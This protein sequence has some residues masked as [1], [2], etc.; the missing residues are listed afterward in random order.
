VL[1][2]R[3]GLPYFHHWDESWVTDNTR[4]MLQTRD[5]KPAT[6]QYGA[7]LSLLGAGIFRT[8][9]AILPKLVMDPNDGVLVRW[10]D[11][12]VT[13]VISASG[14]FAVY[15]A[16]RHATLGDD[17]GR[18][19]GAYAAI[20][21]ATAAELVSHGRYAVTDANLAA[22]CAWSLAFAAL[23]FQSGSLGSAIG[24]VLFAA[25][26]F[27]FKLTALTALAIPTLALALKPLRHGR[28]R[29]PALDHTVLLA[30]LPASAAVFFVLNP[31][32]LIDWKEA[33][34]DIT[35]RVTQVVTGGVGVFMIKKP[36][37]EHLSAV[38]EGIGLYGFHR[39]HAASLL[40]A[41][42]GATGLVIGVRG[43]SRLC[44]VAAIH[45]ALAILSV[46]MT[47]R[48]YLYRNYLVALPALCIGFGVAVERLG[49]RLRAWM[50]TRAW[51][52]VSLGMAG[53]FAIVYVAVP[54]AQAVE[55]QR[56]SADTRVRAVDWIARQPHDHSPVTVATNHV[57]AS[58]GSGQN[59]GA[60]A[61]LA[62]PGIT[63]LGD[64]ETSDDAAASRADYI[65][66]VSYAASTGDNGRVWRFSTVPG[67]GEVARFEANPY[68]HNF[69]ITPT[70]SGRFDA[71]VLRRGAGQTHGDARAVRAPAQPQ[72]P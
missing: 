58:D 6:Y 64:V 71:V 68:E 10:I 34:N 15:V 72:R 2:L 28:F 18:V 44:A 70:W 65:L 43:R 45:A 22:L 36:G 61:T 56:L 53:A 27:S 8:I 35:V 17:R 63:F 25:L 26:A 13:V 69:D 20:L 3:L 67:Y 62:R 50:P 51:V 41:V 42:G 24:M 38:A 60:R 37:W 4:S 66:D 11:R 9:Q 40:A 48:S 31:H 46:A 33:L 19:R 5:L 57:I 23:F 59:D 14:A 30:A 16:A 54:F 32:V 12:A 29:S 7:P 1:G 39:W 21:Y 47:S 52:P 55:T 49:T